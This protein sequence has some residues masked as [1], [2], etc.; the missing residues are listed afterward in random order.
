LLRLARTQALGFLRK[1][2]ARISPSPGPDPA[3]VLPAV[4]RLR[5]AHAA[6]LTTRQRRHF[7]A[8]L[9]VE[10]AAAFYRR[11]DRFV[12]AA[13]LLRSLLRAPRGNAAIAAVLH[14]RRTQRDSRRE[15]RS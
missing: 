4:A 3:K 12:A 8:A 14:N 15:R 11:G 5:S 13:L 2:L 6:L 7:A 1:P 10:C 9:D